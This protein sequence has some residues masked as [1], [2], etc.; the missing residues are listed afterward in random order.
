MQLDRT[1]VAIRTRRISEIG[2]LAF[3]IVRQYARPVIVTFAWGALPWA[4]LN[5]VILLPPFIPGWWGYHEIDQWES[6][7]SKYLIWLTTLIILQAPAAGVA[8]TVFLGEAVFESAPSMNTVRRRVFGTWKT[9]L[10]SLGVIRLPLIA[11]V[12]V[13]FRIGE[14]FRVGA[15]FAMP[16]FL[17]LIAIVL[18]A[19]RPFMPEIL[20]LEQCPIRAKDSVITARRRSKNLHRP[21]AGD[22]N[23][24]MMVVTLTLAAISAAIYGA[25]DGLVSLVLGFSSSLDLFKYFVL[26]PLSLWV[27]ACMSIV[28]RLLNYLDCRIRLEGWDVELSVRAEAIRQFGD[29]ANRPADR[30][31]VTQE[32]VGQ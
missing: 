15:D 8:T 32:V 26:L 14:P 31:A 24:R 6:T 19:N 22:L 7:L 29:P 27:A 30:P 1:H 5:M 23:G 13:V 21:Y 28:V 2:D 11:M 10:T 16:I 18:R 25:S 17:L 3:A 12:W 4:I 20:L 9:W